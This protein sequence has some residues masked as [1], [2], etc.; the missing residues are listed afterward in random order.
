ME[1]HFTPSQNQGKSSP[2]SKRNSRPKGSIQ[3]ILQRL[4][5]YLRPHTKLLLPTIGA[6]LITSLIELSPPWI[7]RHAIDE[8]I[9]GDQPQRI[10]MAAVGLLLIALVQGGID[11]LRLY[12]TAFTGQRIVF[13][14]R[15][16]IFEH[17][18]RLSFSF[19]DEARTGDLMS[20]VTSD[21]EILNNF[22]GRAAVIVITNILTLVG[23][24]L[25]L[26]V[27]SWQLALVYLGLVPLI[28]L[29][30][31]AYA[32]KVRPAWKRVQQQL[33]AFTAT[34]HESLTGIFL[35]KVLGHESYERKRVKQKSNQVL[36]AN[37]ETSRI[38]AGCLNLLHNDIR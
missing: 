21:I 18:N 16:I 12:L 36:S 29:G 6:A 26:M 15:N 20:R 32:R 37:I 34:L 11:F 33:A 22:F 25:V 8:F 14:I 9:I 30:M 35:V 31:W 10:W 19:F 1:N 17:I 38:A 3:P 2:A 28:I 27:W 24:F 5:I 13:K 7:I 4:L 23:I